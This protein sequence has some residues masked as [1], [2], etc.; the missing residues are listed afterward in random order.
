MDGVDLELAVA[1]RVDLGRRVGINA[2]GVL[3]A[4]S[5]VIEVGGQKLSTL[6]TTG[7]LCVPRVQNI[8][9]ASRFDILEGAIDIHVA[10]TEWS[11]GDIGL[12]H[13]S[14]LFVQHGEV[15]SWRGAEARGILRILK[16]AL[17]AD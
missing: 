16:V 6:V 4:L 7:A 13:V 9:D 2:S 3:V 1:S 17:L 11:R 14:I 12:G 15:V 10:A 8:V 5:I